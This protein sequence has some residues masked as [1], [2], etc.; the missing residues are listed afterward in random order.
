MRPEVE[1]YGQGFFF[2]RVR[3]KVDVIQ[4]EQNWQVSVWEVCFDDDVRN[5][6]KSGWSC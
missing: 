3:E 1:G 2:I 6:T 5:V 4:D